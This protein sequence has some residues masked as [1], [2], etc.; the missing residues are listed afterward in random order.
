MGCGGCRGKAAG[1]SPHR[2]H[3]RGSGC[4]APAGGAPLVPPKP[5]ARSKKPLNTGPMPQGRAPAAAWR[6]LAA[7]GQETD[8][9]GKGGPASAQGD[10]RHKRGSMRHAGSYA[11]GPGALAEGGA[12]AP[13]LPP[14]RG[15]QRAGVGA[16]RAPRGK[17]GSAARGPR[18][19]AVKRGT[20][21]A[22]VRGGTNCLCTPR[23]TAVHSQAGVRGR[24]AAAAPGRGA[25]AQ[26]PR[27]HGGRPITPRARRRPPPRRPAP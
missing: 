9:Q 20:G 2:C 18:S 26:R 21:G 4:C 5:P 17:G 25:R 19:G 12:A 24:A 3:R 8:A 22:E 15:C 27:R 23:T 16:Q 7:A 6:R 10:T 11:Q 1:A 13:L 14:P